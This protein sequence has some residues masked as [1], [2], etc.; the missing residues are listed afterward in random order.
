MKARTY[1]LTTNKRRKTY[2]IRVYEGGKL[3]SKYRTCPQGADF[4]EFWTENDIK[5]Y[6]KMNSDYYEVK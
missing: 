5:N 6:L 4:S 3:I 1:K 2:T